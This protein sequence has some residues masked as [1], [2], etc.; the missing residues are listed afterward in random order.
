MDRK[1]G[2]L[3]LGIFF[4]VIIVRLILAFSLPTFTYESYYHLRQVEHIAQTGL[5]L[6]HDELSYGGRELRFL[7]GFHYI[8]AFFTLVLPLEFV[9]KALPNLLMASLTLLVFLLAWK[10]TRQ[11][12]SSLI[13][14]AVAGFLPILYNTN[15]F[16]PDTLFLPLMLLAVYAFLHLDEKEYLL[17]YL[18]CL[19]ALSL[20]TAMTF[21]LLMGFGI[22]LILSLLEGKRLSRAELELILFSAFF[23]LWV[24]FLFFKRTLLEQGVSFIWQNVPSAILLDYFPSFSITQALVSISLIPFLAGLWVVYKSLFEMK[25]R[26]LFLLISFAISTIFLMWMRVIRFRLSLSFLALILAILFATFYGQLTEQFRRTKFSRYTPQIS[27]IFVIIV[28]ASLLVP[29]LGT[30]LRQDTPSTDQVAAFQWL[31]RNTE[32][33]AGIVSTLEEGHLVTYYAHR[34][35]MMDDKFNLIT[36]GEQRFQ[37]LQSLYTGSFETQAVDLMEQ[38]DLQYIILS[39]QARE[40]YSIA[41]LKYRTSN[42][43][44]KV[45]DQKEI[46]I[47]RRLC[48]LRLLPE[49]EEK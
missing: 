16:T 27:V 9:A 31:G 33:N 39:P 47:Y 10:T 41:L 32:E 21:L 6:F 28:L 42:C 20:T 17:L 38:Y 3:L 22:Y 26:Q 45:Y 46:R 7:P 23:F 48:T 24:Q 35:N 43:L 14:A 1:E 37:D 29:A 8:M 11:S 19:L 40:K 13:A 34:R 49:L 18:F 5:P 15:S 30:A 25:S 12:R 4:V 36:D 44:R 2:L